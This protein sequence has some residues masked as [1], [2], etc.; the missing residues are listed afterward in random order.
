M[1]PGFPDPS[2]ATGGAH[3]MGSPFRG[4][5][6]RGQRIGCD[7]PQIAN[8]LPLSPRLI[9]VYTPTSQRAS[10]APKDITPVTGR[11]DITC[12]LHVAPWT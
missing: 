2:P 8:A 7:P 4:R 1:G 3:L 6:R 9:S 12:Q 5:D 10:S 11:P